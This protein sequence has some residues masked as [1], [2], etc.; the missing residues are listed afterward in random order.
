[1]IFP[2]TACIV[3][4]KLGMTN[5]AMAFDVQAVCS[6]FVYAVTVADSLIRKIDDQKRALVIG[7]T[8]RIFLIGRIAVPVCSLATV[9]GLSR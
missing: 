3:Q 5:H 9:R 7:T 4:S 1:M 6:G 2:S 8:L